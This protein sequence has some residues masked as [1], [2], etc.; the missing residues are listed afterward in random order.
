MKNWEA[1][2]IIMNLYKVTN[3]PSAVAAVVLFPFFGTLLSPIFAAAAMGISSVNVV[4]NA[5]RL[6]RARL[7]SFLCS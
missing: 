1:G 6:R 2:P 5:L 3:V 4:T 7:G